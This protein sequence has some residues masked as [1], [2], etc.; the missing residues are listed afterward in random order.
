MSQKIVV[1]VDGT[2][3]GRAALR[4]ALA[5]AQNNTAEVQLVNVTDDSMLVV[6]PD[7]KAAALEA[8]E[9]LLREELAYAKE[10]DA[11][12]TITALAIVGHPI[13]ELEKVSHTAALLVLGG[14]HGHRFAGAVFGTRSVKIAAVSQCPVV[15]V[16]P[17]FTVADPARVV[18][19]VDGSNAAR[20][21]VATA[22]RV[23]A[24]SRAILHTVYAWMPPTAPGLQHLWSSEFVQ[25]QEDEAKEALAV[26]TAGLAADYP[27]LQI[28]QEIV[29]QPPVQAL[30]ESAKDAQ[31]LVVGNRGRG[32]IAR[33][34]LGSVSHGVLQALPCPVM[35]VHQK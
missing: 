23:A 9:A 20:N 6:T 16:P 18:V 31:L 22:A 5:W 24:G 30:I 28:T 17:E 4:W 32:N 3:E 26:G 21:A 13:D 14:H 27:D 19:G 33:L 35:V 10:Q 11:A 34:L 15:I 8:S 12:A 1:G 25:Q 7:F 2:A 29:Q